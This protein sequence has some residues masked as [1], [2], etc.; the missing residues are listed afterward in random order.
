MRGGRKSSGLRR[1][2]SRIIFYFFPLAL[3]FVTFTTALPRPF[4]LPTHPVST[5]S[6]FKGLLAP[7]LKFRTFEW[8]PCS[9]PTHCTYRDIRTANGYRNTCVLE[10]HP[11]FLLRWT[12]NSKK[13]WCLLC[14][15]NGSMKVATTPRFYQQW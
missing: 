15:H 9:E 3:P 1:K 5:L 12:R 14:E 4:G 2:A 10:F 6:L 11:H 13:A 8:L 7:A